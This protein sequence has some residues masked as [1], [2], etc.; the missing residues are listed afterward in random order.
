M[1][2][3]QALISPTPQRLAVSAYL[4][5]KI[6]YS[7]GKCEGFPRFEG[8]CAKSALYENTSLQFRL[9]WERRVCEKSARCERL[10]IWI[11][12]I[13]LI[14]IS[15]CANDW[16]YV[17]CKQSQNMAGFRKDLKIEQWFNISFR[18]CIPKARNIY[19]LQEWHNEQK[20]AF[21]IAL[22]TDKHES[23]T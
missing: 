17:L 5:I 22:F 16:E 1:P 15:I 7:T 11:R 19:F 12:A 18:T 20:L 4:V 13:S 21:R 10:L 14:K 8:R 6:R 3:A 2:T 9:R 23:S